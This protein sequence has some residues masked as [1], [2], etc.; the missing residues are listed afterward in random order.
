MATGQQDYLVMTLSLAILQVYFIS[1]VVCTKHKKIP[2]CALLTIG[3][4]GKTSKFLSAVNRS[5]DK[6]ASFYY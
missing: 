3:S 1:G 4:K 6:I 2:L 5:E